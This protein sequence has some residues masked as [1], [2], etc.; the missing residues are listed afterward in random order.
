MFISQISFAV[1][2]FKSTQSFG[3]DS[4]ENTLGFKKRRP[5]AISKKMPLILIFPKLWE[6]SNLVN[7]S[8]ISAKQTWKVTLGSF[9]KA[10]IRNVDRKSIMC[11]VL[12]Q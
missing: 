2:K 12:S 9:L 5:T 6:S 11:D 4:N 1:E 8:T 10:R 7:E 3:K